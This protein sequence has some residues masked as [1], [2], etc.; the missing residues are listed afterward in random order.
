MPAL[1]YSFLFGLLILTTA[2]A[3][4]KEEPPKPTAPFFLI[5]EGD[6]TL[7]MET[8]ATASKQIGVPASSP[9][10]KTLVI[11]ERV[12]EVLR[13]TVANQAGSRSER[14]MLGPY[15]LRKL[16]PQLP[17]LVDK[18]PTANPILDLQA[19]L[20]WLG[21]DNYKDT[22][23]DKESKRFTHFYESKYTHRIP[24]QTTTDPVTQAMTEIP[25][26][27]VVTVTRIGIDAETRF[28]I[29]MDI[30]TKTTRYNFQVGIPKTLTMPPDFQKAMN[31]VTALSN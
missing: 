1:L 15:L 6:L 31:E 20:N 30:D 17:V 2:P 21:M 25:S 19:S 9:P 11:I 26:S 12:G 3:Q 18:I 10:E 16:T 5:P 8:S 29:S 14:W 24:A 13:E 4:Q 22:M 28:P 7:R 27:E 23:I